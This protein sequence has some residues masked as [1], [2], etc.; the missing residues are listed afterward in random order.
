MEYNQLSFNVYNVNRS[1]YSQSRRVNSGVDWACPGR[2]P[3]V[4]SRFR[5]E[6]STLIS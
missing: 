5:P 4:G 6:C 3:R 1:S 2:H